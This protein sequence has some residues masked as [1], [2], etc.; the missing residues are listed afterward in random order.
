VDNRADAS[1]SGRLPAQ[2]AFTEY[3]V[4]TSETYL[5]EGI[6]TGPDG[7]LWFAEYFANKIRRITTAGVIT[8]FPIL[9]PASRATAPSARGPALKHAVLPDY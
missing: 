3:P 6:T 9:T 1:G 2:V 4:P 5:A 8:E 7:N